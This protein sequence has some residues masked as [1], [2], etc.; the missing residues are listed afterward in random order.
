MISGVIR[1]ST[2]FLSLKRGAIEVMKDLV[3]RGHKLAFISV[4]KKGHLASKSRFLK[5]WT[6][7]FMDLDDHTQGHGFY[8]THFKG[9]V[10]VD[11]II[12][13]RHEYLNQFA[14]RPEV[15]KI[16]KDTPY[17]QFE[18]LKVSVDYTADSWYKIGK[19]LE[20]I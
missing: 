10:A 7:D 2:T 14:S 12:D 5:R 1:S 20:G 15:I 9:N 17:E 19:F 18:E 11:V 16:L 4:C 13:D 6:S 3:A 8:A